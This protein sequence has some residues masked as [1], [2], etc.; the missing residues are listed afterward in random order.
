MAE[1]NAEY[2]AIGWMCETGRGHK[3]WSWSSTTVYDRPH[4]DGCFEVYRAAQTDGR[5]GDAEDA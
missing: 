2:V 5:I 3:Q 4:C 1:L